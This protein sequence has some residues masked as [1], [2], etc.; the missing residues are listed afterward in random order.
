MYKYIKRI[1]D[2]FFVL[3][4]II[5]ILPLFIII[6]IVIFIQDGKSP[7]FKQQ[8]IGRFGKAFNFYKFR[9]MSVDTPDVVSIDKTKLKI[10][11]FGRLIRRTNLDELPQILNILKGDMSWIG[12][13]PPIS[14]QLKLIELRRNNESLKLKPGLTGWAQINS[15]DN[16]T[17][18]VKANF[19]GEYA[20]NISLYLDFK[21]MMRTFLYFTKKPP[22]Y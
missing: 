8:R 21:I 10:T 12:P 3:V 19:D 9:S 22:T 11:P 20:K 16:M 5:L 4:C 15:Y 6:P 1:L 7:I 17:E 18:E 14:T 13:R 2:I